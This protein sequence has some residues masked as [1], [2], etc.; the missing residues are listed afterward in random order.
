MVLV[1]SGT[2]RL[3]KDQTPD[4]DSETQSIVRITPVPPGQDFVEYQVVDITYTDEFLT[5]AAITKRNER[6]LKSD[7]TQLPDA[8]LTELQVTAWRTYRQELRDVPEQAG[9]PRNI[10]WPVKPE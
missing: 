9:Y 6:L 8:P 7:W 2:Q 5:A 3:V 4:Y 1:V 10:N